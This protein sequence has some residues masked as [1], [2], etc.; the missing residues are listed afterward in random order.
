MKQYQVVAEYSITRT[1]GYYHAESEE[2]AI[3][4]ARSEIY[5]MAGELGVSG[6]DNTWAEEQEA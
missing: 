1:I 5:E 6:P 3:R 4:N 2:E